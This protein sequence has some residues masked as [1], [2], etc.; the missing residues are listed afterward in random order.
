MKQGPGQTGFPAP[1]KGN[2]AAQKGTDAS[3]LKHPSCSLPHATRATACG[4]AEAS[5]RRNLVFYINKIQARMDLGPITY[6]VVMLWQCLPAVVENAALCQSEFSFTNSISWTQIPA[7]QGVQKQP[8]PRPN[9][10]PSVPT[11]PFCP[12]LL[13]V[14]RSQAAGRAEQKQGLCLVLSSLLCLLPRAQLSGENKGRPG[15]GRAPLLAFRHSGLTCTPQVCRQARRA[16]GR[17]AQRQTE[18][19]R[20]QIPHLLS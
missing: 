7:P 8:C 11:R 17:P 3:A 5:G 19:F 4:T 14:S 12:E 6:R 2:Q 20:E 13:W 10:P 1:R 18:A 16:R 15:Q 9:Q